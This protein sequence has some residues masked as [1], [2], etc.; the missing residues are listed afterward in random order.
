MTTLRAV[1]FDLD[2][3]LADT[4]PD[5]AA[6]LNSVRAEQGLPPLP[7]AEIRPHVSHGALVM[8]Q[9]GFS[10]GKDDPTALPLRDRLVEIYAANIA[11]H[12]RL[13]P[14]MAEILALLEKNNMPWGIVTNKQSYLTTPLMAHL[15]LSERACCIISGDTLAEKKP[16][17]APLLHAAAQARCA[18]QACLYVGDAERDI[19]AGR[20]A[21]MRTAAALFGYLDVADRPHTWG[22]DYLFASP[23]ELLVWLQQCLSEEAAL[24]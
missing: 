7:F 12:T 6:A 13:F 1:L 11:V 14:G 22:A 16:H 23:H 8:V 15:S 10:L 24:A 18:P 17:P 4:A 21:G 3:T 5:L 20:R 2:G 9:H 19:E